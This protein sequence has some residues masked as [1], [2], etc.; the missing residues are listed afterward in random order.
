MLIAGP[1]L[2]CP[3][4]GSKADM[5]G[6]M[7]EYA[8]ATFAFCCP[9][10]DSEFSKDPAKA[11]ASPKLKGKNAGL[12]LFD[13]VSR[14]RLA[15]DKAKAF[16]TYQGIVFPFESEANKAKFDKDPKA[17]GTMPKKE[18]MTCPVSGE[19]I[20]TYASSVGYFDVEGVRYYI[21]CA[22]CLPAMEKDAAKHAA[23]HAAKAAAPKA[24][25]AKADKN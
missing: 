13:P 22:G 24:V 25:K 1:D 19:A 17:F 8:G 9:G 12:S 4:M 14:K 18:V 7:V 20:E 10:C 11:L 21:C 15:V 3:I 5:K 2:I 23:T 6:P 16:V